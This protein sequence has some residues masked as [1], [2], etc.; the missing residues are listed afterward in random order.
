MELSDLRIFSAI[1]RE[2]G[3]TRAAETVA[4]RAIQPHHPDRAVERRS[5][6]ARGRTL[7]TSG[8]WKRFLRGVAAPSEPAPDLSRLASEANGKQS[9]VHWP[10][11]S[12][13][14]A[15]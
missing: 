9:P 1:V 8:L 10:I 12:P 2:G 7:R 14:P 3:V 5:S 4:S 11:K 6:G 15:S 13:T